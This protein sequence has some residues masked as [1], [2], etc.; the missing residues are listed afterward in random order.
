MKTK[1]ILTIIAV[2]TFGIGV[3]V[4]AYTSGG[5]DT[6]SCCP[7]GADS[8]PMKMK[9]DGDAMKHDSCPM[10]MKDASGK[11]MSCDKCDCCKGDSCPMKHKDDAE[12]TSADGT[13]KSC[14]CPCCHH[15]KEKKGEVSS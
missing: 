2:L 4:F 9:H 5:T 7:K 1:I 10:K 6:P 13:A 15:D 11:E 14:D 8:C 12:K 3:A